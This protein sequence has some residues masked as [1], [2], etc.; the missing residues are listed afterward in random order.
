[1]YWAA[2][3]RA[4]AL[5]GALTESSRS[6]ISASAPEPT[7]LASFRSSSPG[8]NSRELMTLRLRPL[9]HHRLALAL[10]HHFAALVEGL[11][12]ELDDAGI[13]ARLAVPLAE[14]LRR[15]VQRIAVEHGFG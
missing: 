11:V 2:I 14:H 6:R 12:Q 5:R 10:C 1:M 7:P 4:A 15:E 13:R 8:M 3:A 9:V